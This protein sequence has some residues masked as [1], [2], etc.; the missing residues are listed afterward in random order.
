[1]QSVSR[2]MIRVLWFYLGVLITTTG[3]G[4]VIKPGVGAAPWDI[5]HLGLN[6]RSGIPL[7]F[8]I[9]GTGVL[10]IGLN[11][12]LGIRP[13]VGMVLN[14]LSVGPTLQFLLPVLPAPELPAFRW[15]MLLM[16]VGI[17]GF[18]T[19]LYSSADLGTGPRDGM[20]IG[21]TRRLNLPVGV[22]KNGID[23]AVTVAGWLLGGPLGAGT[24]LVALLMGPSV[25]MGMAL[26]AR[27]AKLPPF[28]GFIR[29]VSLK[30]APV[31]A[32]GD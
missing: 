10:L 24:L 9:Q 7:A 31:A 30:R 26:T 12:L 13:T 2:T 28:S 23:I 19:A 8:V 14:M 22:I 20:M 5:F 15:L 25:Q 21:L 3:Y 18:G 1:M 6:L 16:G 11:L 32:E 4:M 17:A 29:P 27:L